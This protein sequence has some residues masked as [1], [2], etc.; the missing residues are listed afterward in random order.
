VCW[1]N[2]DTVDGVTGSEETK[3]HDGVA[4]V[5]VRLPKVDRSNFEKTKLK[6][7]KKKKKKKKKTNPRVG[8]AR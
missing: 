6:N 7:F 8:I 5:K 4:H 3:D 1:P 2:D